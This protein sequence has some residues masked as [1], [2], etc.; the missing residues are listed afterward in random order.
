MSASID[1]PEADDVRDGTHARA[2]VSAGAG[3]DDESLT[4]TGPVVQYDDE[5]GTLQVAAGDDDEPTHELF[6]R[7]DRSVAVYEM[8][9]GPTKE[10]GTA[11]SF[12]LFD[13]LDEDDLPAEGSVVSV[14]YDSPRSKGDDPLS[15]TGFV[16]EVADGRVTVLET[17]GSVVRIGPTGDVTVSTDDSGAGRHLG[18]FVRF[19]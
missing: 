8:G 4:V 1:R 5:M 2:I 13:P 12:H 9:D 15:R 14:Y 10:A 6:W 7:D 18:R 3:S 19:E 11:D 16:D 17:D